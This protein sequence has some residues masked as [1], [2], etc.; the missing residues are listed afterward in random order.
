MSRGGGCGVRMVMVGDIVGGV[1]EER[2]V[3][4]AGKRSTRRDGADGLVTGPV[5]EDRGGRTYV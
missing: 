5:W 4:W 1:I 3:E 2:N